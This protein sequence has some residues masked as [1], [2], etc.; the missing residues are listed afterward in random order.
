MDVEGMMS[1]SLDAAEGC[2]GSG[3]PGRIGTPLTERGT[4][5]LPVRLSAVTLSS[6]ALVSSP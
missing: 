2:G 5:T 4:K 6:N 3:R 1:V